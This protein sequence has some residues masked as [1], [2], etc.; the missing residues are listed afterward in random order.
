MK[1]LCVGYPKTG[2]KSCSSALRQLGYKVADFVETLEFLSIVWLDFYEGRATIDDVLEVYDKHGFD[3]NQDLP[4]NVLW[5]ELYRGLGP[6]TKVILTVRDNDEVWWRS[7]CGF[8]TQECKRDSIG[9]FCT[10]AL[11]NILNLRGYSGPEM[12]ACMKVA[13]YAMGQEFDPSF[14]ENNFS[15]KK[16]V[17]ILT[18]KERRLRAAY[19][20]HNMYVKSIV[21]ASNLLVW[22]VKEG[23]AP[24]CAF[25]DKPI[26]NGPIPHDNKTGD[27]QFLN[28]YFFE[29]PGGKLVLGHL[30]WNMAMLCIKVGVV[31]YIGYKQHRTNGKWLPLL[32]EPLMSRITSAYYK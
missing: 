10:Q 24:L 25:L 4:G 1:L 32:I 22:N 20:K 19:L 17:Q 14:T 3:C 7:W 6:D 29:S 5:E 11:W 12:Q 13:E 28:D 21:P 15:V 18:N 2:S 27:V 16:S 30:K 9:D 8:M 31:G 26:P 23:W